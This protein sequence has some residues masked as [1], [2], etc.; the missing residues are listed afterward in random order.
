M[1]RRYLTSMA[2][3]APDPADEAGVVRAIKNKI[4]GRSARRMTDLGLLLGEVMPQQ[5]ID[6]ATAVIYASAYSETR[7]LES[8]LDSLPYAS[9]IG[10]Q[11]SI[12][13]SGVEQVLIHRNQPIGAFFPLAGEPL[14]FWHALQCVLNCNH[15]QVL[16]LAGEQ[17]GEWTLEHGLGYPYTYA[18][19][20]QFSREPCAE[21]IATLEW[22][23]QTAAA[24][25]AP[26]PSLHALIPDLVA[27][28]TLRYQHKDLGEFALVFER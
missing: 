9:P 1:N 22:D 12:H 14:L 8:Y 19:R 13:P 18:L 24:A 4:G 28:R 6:A 23:P 21:T 5:P 26:S 20:M 25:Q 11:T 7:A 15:P 17:R 16:L 3:L 2:I 27:R 10:F